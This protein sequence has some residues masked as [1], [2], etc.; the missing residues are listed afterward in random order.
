MEKK[1]I[2]CDSLINEFE[3]D[4]QRKKVDHQLKENHEKIYLISIDR[5]N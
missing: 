1:N 5:M 2:D 3:K 4:F